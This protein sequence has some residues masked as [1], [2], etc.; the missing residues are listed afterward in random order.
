[1]P[2][3]RILAL[4]AVPGLLI[5]L[6][7]LLV[8]AIVGLPV[9]LAI[10]IALVATVAVAALLY[11]LS[12]TRALDALHTR[13][14]VEGER[15]RLDNLLDAL[16]VNGGFDRPQVHRV[17]TAARNSAV[18]SDGATHLVITDGLIDAVDYMDLEALLA[19][20]LAAGEH[21]E[22]QYRTRMVGLLSLLPD[23]LQQRLADR[24]LDRVEVFGGDVEGAQVTRYPPGQV[25][26]LEVLAEGDNRVGGVAP[27]GSDLWL[28]NPLGAHAEDPAHPALEDR[29]AL[30]RE[31]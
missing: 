2:D 28:A 21:S 30:L 14:L 15:P 6:I 13:P 27:A 5:G 23:G 11:R 1:M 24:L 31:L 3:T 16:C 20:Q 8:L 12:G 9:W 25:A 22:L 26:L 19:H 17:D 7:A 10:V 4:I 29:I 18:L